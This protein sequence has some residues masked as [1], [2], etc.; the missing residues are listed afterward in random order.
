[1]TEVLRKNIKPF[2][3]AGMFFSSYFSTNKLYNAIE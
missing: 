1:M 2:C 3:E